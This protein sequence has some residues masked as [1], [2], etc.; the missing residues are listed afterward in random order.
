MR[1]SQLSFSHLA[2]SALRGEASLTGTLSSRS[3]RKIK[4]RTNELERYIFGALALLW[5]CSLPPWPFLLYRQERV[6]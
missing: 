1:R 3:K 6:H 5:F 2:S 4:D